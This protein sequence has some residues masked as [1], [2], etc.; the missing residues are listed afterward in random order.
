M[1]HH[2]FW[3]IEARGTRVQCDRRSSAWVVRMFKLDHNWFGNTHGDGDLVNSDTVTVEQ[4]LLETDHAGRFVIL[5][6]Q[7]YWS[8]VSL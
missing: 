3:E 6:C 1:V 2:I 7:T 4:T 8:S 5:I